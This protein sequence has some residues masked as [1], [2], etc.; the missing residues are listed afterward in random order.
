MS[1]ACNPTR[2]RLHPQVIHKDLPLIHVPSRTIAQGIASSLVARLETEPGIK[3]LQPTVRATGRTGHV[4]GFVGLSSMDQS[5]GLFPLDLHWDPAPEGA[6]LAWLVSRLSSHPPQAPHFCSVQSR[7]RQAME[8]GYKANILR[9]PKPTAL[10]TTGG[11]GAALTRHL[12]AVCPTGTAR[13]VCQVVLFP[14]GPAQP[15]KSISDPAAA[16]LGPSSCLKEAMSNLEASL[17]AEPD[18]PRG[19]HGLCQQC[20]S[21]GRATA[22]DD[23]HEVPLEEAFQAGSIPTGCSCGSHV[24]SLG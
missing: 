10:Q 16:A 19:A 15:Q 18:L 1:G 17:K 20:H 12:N 3:H 8:Q 13:G 22:P 11:R 4:L 7:M 21:T 2:L 14:L 6:L 9:L 24:A 23:S 5:Q